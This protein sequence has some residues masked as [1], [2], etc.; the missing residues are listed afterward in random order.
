M[1]NHIILFYRKALFDTI[2]LYSDHS[3]HSDF[4]AE[5]FSGRVCFLYKFTNS[6]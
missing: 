6:L 5:H 3:Y 4:L 2:K 1:F